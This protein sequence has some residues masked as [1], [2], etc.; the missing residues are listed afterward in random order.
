MFFLK[1]VLPKNSLQKLRRIIMVVYIKC[2]RKSDG[3]WEGKVK[4]NLKQLWYLKMNE[5]LNGRL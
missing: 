1:M 4:I 5:K 3:S 2:Y